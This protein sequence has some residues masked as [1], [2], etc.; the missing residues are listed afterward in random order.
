MATCLTVGLLYPGEMGASLGTLLAGRGVRVVTT[1][2][3][4]SERTA[5]RARDAGLVILSSLADLVR[6]SSIVFS[7]VETSAAAQVAQSYAA[8]AAAAPDG[9][10]YVDVNSIGPELASQIGALITAAG[11]DFIDASIN[12]LAKNLSTGGTFFLSGPRADEVA[13]L[14]GPAVRTRVLGGEIGRASAMKMLL[15]GL[16]KGLCALFLE[17]AALAQRRDMLAEMMDAC[18]M[19]YPGITALIDRMLPTYARHAGRR[20][21]EMTEL[22]STARHA[23]MAPCVIDAIRDL[24]ELMAGV[25]FA[26]QDG[27]SVAALVERVVSAGLFDFEHA[28][29]AASR[30]NG[31]AVTNCLE[32]RL[33]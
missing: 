33:S 5:C 26:D 18:T 19:I 21:T 32:P 1:L 27:A 23:D 3:G 31:L 9:A 25:E 13:Q 24:H 29:L 14:V 10:I 28:P 8:L 20:A 2:A 22:K 4:R 17:L 15:G 16:S 30:T 12:G 7:L 6:E 11:V